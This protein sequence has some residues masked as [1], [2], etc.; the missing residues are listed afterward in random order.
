MRSRVT[1]F[2]LGLMLVLNLLTGC[3]LVD[4]KKKVGTLVQ[5]WSQGEDREIQRYAPKTT[6]V[7]ADQVARDRFLA[8]L[9][10]DAD[11]ESTL[12]VDL[13]RNFL[14]LGSYSKCMDQSRVWMD[15][16]RTAVWF[17][18]Y[19]PREDRNTN[20]VWAPLTIDVWAVPRDELGETPVEL[21]RTTEP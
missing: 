9:P 21:L 2:G 13:S 15:A 7:L 12:G 14:V 5:S 6:T 4:G 19:I 3:A 20:C 17:E 10:A 8:R 16:G 11:R 18:T 1:A